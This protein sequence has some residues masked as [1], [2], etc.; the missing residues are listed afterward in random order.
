MFDLSVTTNL[1]V[2]V[3]MCALALALIFFA[4]DVFASKK[5]S[6]AVRATAIVFGVVALLVGLVFGF[7]AVGL[8][9]G[10]ITLAGSDMLVGSLRVPQVA[11]VASL[12]TYPA[13]WAFS[14]VLVAL[15]LADIIGEALR[16]GKKA[17]TESVS[18]EKPAQ[19]AAKVE[20]AA[21]ADGLGGEAE[22]VE[23][24]F[25]EASANRKRYDLDD[26]R[27]IMDEISGLVDN[28]GAAE[29]EKPSEPTLE[30]HSDNIAAVG[31]DEEDD[32]LDFGYEPAGESARDYFSELPTDEEGEDEAEYESDEEEE[33]S[34][35]AEEE[36]NEEATED[37]PEETESEKETAAEEETENSEEER[38]SAA[39]VVAERVGKTL[40][41]SRPRE[42][43]NYTTFAP[44]E[45]ES[46]AP[47]TRKVTIKGRSDNVKEVEPQIGGLPMTKRHV[48]I[49][50]RNV[51]NMFSEYLKTKSAD[52][53]ERIE[54]S[55]NTI[56]IK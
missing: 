12:A 14:A 27:G 1:V 36:I 32:E 19:A 52:E 46:A 10:F 56:I 6:V 44:K 55:I 49:N 23:A 9:V 50:R 5:P 20:P 43:E 45:G 4:V 3:V 29:E 26:V 34:D 22:L 47:P 51:V 54:S 33:E 35:E 28:M 13:T 7:A 8:K 2:F 48:I 15:A 41:P 21:A 53:K 30:K 25:S 40:R 37:K 17:E 18:P 16:R 39:A 11:S 38:E 42:I 24:A 31:A